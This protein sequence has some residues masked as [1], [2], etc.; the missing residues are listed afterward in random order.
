MVECKDASLLIGVLYAVIR[1]RDSRLLVTSLRI[2]KV[3]FKTSTVDTT[4]M[5][6]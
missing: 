6:I 2:R 4:S 5:Q 1:S 3:C